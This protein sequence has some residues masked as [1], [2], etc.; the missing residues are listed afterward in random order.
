ML[1][2][3]VSLTSSGEIKLVELHRSKTIL[4]IEEKYP[5]LCN[6]TL[7]V[8][9]NSKFRTPWNIIQTLIILYYIISIPLRFPYT[10]QNISPING[11]IIIDYIC[12]LLLLIDLIL[13]TFYF[14]ITLT[15]N[16][17]HN[18]YIR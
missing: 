4:N 6:K 17:G 15:T 5:K 1:D 16:I 2:E 8:F 11:S 13:N 10:V 7:I 14:H 9:I 12:D 18:D 3:S